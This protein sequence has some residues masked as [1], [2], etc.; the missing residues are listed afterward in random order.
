MAWPC[1]C[2]NRAY[3]AALGHAGAIIAGGKGT[4]QDKI[5]ALEAANVSVVRSPAMIGEEM[6]KFFP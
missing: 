5:T 1:C 4:A 6:K 2:R 3:V